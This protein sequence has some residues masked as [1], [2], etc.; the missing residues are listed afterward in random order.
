MDED[1][2]G[3]R[4]QA[5]RMAVVTG[6]A[7]P[8]QHDINNLLTVVFANLELLKRTA[9]AGGPQRQ[10]DRI[11][12][13][14]K[15][16]ERSTRAMLS[17]IRRVPVGPGVFRLSEMLT[18]LEPLL[19]L[20]LPTPGMLSLDIAEDD[21]PVLA[22]RAALE[23]ALLGLAQQTAEALGRGESLDITLANRPGE[24]GAPDAVALCCRLP[25]GMAEEAL[26]AL[27]RLLPEGESKEA[28]PGLRL[29]CFLLPRQAEAE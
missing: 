13:A 26:Q 17:M 21:W 14:A 6:L 22:E 29:H 3:L 20:L 27:R 1:I 19:H 8:V 18:V 12:E 16:F 2:A 7:R 15:R 4:R 9:A 23:E 11:Q 25:D 5:A 10:L 24:G 28:G